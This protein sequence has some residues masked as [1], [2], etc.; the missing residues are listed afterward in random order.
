MLDV[1]EISVIVDGSTQ[2]FPEQAEQPFVFDLLLQLREQDVVFDAGIVALYIGAKDEL[3]LGKLAQN[4]TDNCLGSTVSC[5][6][7]ASLG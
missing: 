6:V 2:V 4:F 3:V 5:K 7:S 1:F